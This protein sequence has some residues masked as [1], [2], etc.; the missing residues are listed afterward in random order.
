MSGDNISRKVCTYETESLYEA[1]HAAENLSFYFIGSRMHETLIPVF[2]WGFGRT[3]V[4]FLCD[5]IWRTKSPLSL[6]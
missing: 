3:L 6:K 2:F 1:M 5:P 4:D